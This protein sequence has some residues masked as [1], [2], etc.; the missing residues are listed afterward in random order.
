MRGEGC[1]KIDNRYPRGDTGDSYENSHFVQF[2]E[3]DE[4]L[5]DSVARYV[6]DALTDDVG[7]IVIATQE[8]LVAVEALLVK[9]RGGPEVDRLKASL[10]LTLADAAV[11]LDRFMVAGRPDQER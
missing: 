3:N 5:A 4:L 11:M 2:F 6:L 7:L 10:Q 8:H 1:I 9:A